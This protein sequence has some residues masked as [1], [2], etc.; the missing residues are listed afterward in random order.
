[1]NLS[2]NWFKPGRVNTHGSLSGVIND[3]GSSVTGSSPGFA[4]EANQDLRL[5]SGSAAINAGTTLHASALPANAAAMQYVKHRSG[6]SRPSDSALDIGAFEYRTAAA[7]R[8]DLN[9]DGAVNVVDFQTLVNLVLSGG[10]SG[11]GDLNRDGR[12]DVIDV[13][14]LINVILG[15]AACPG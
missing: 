4:D 9:G 6:E 13:Q 15:T 3:D 14:I 11:A 10:A 2:H 5:V 1:M 8:C 12:T 7:S